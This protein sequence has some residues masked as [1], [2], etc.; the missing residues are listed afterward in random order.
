[1]TGPESGA[2]SPITAPG[3]GA[4]AAQITSAEPVKTRR[5][6]KR[7]AVPAPSA[8]P[9]TQPTEAPVVD[10][11]LIAA[12]ASLGQD[13][14]Q[15]AP[16]ETSQ[17]LPAVEPP[18][19][20]PVVETQPTGVETPRTRGRGGRRARTSAA[21]AEPPSVE[22]V[23]IDPD[24]VAAMASLGEEPEAT[25]AEPADA[26][27]PA[28]TEPEEAPA[29]TTEPPTGGRGG[30]LGWA[31]KKLPN[32]FKPR[33]TPP[34]EPPI[35]TPAEPAGDEEDLAAVEEASAPP[36]EP[37]E[38]P[39]IQPEENPAVTPGEPAGGEEDRV[40]GEETPVATAEEPVVEPEP[41]ISPTERSRRERIIEA[42]S[43]RFENTR[44]FGKPL[45]ELAFR[46]IGTRGIR[47]GARELAKGIVSWSG[48]AGAVGGGIA[49][50]AVTGAFV[51]AIAGA[52]VEYVRQ[53]DA[54]LSVR[55]LE[56][57]PNL[58][59][60]RDI[61]LQKL[62]ETRQHREVFTQLDKGKLSRAAIFGAITGAGAG[63]IAEIPGVREFLNE[64]VRRFMPNLSGV[65]QAA[66]EAVKSAGTAGAVA[67][68]AI[69]Q[70][71]GVEGLGETASGI[72]Q[73][74]GE[75][76]GEVGRW[77][78]IGGAGDAARE[79]AAK[80]IA[81][82][83]EIKAA[84]P[85]SVVSK[86][87]FDTLQSQVDSL[88]TQ[89]ADS[90]A[91]LD[92]LR[93]SAQPPLTEYV[94]KADFANLQRDL[95]EVKTSLAAAREA[96][97]GVLPSAEQA[98]ATA[99][100]VAEQAAAGATEATQAQLNEAF[101]TLNLSDNYALQGGDSVAGI[102]EKLGKSLGLTN[103]QAW[104]LGK[105]LAEENGV[106]SQYYGTAGNILDRSLPIGQVMNMQGVKGLALE[107]LK[108]KTKI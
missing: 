78:N 55:A 83:E 88:N 80:A 16:A 59:S 97:S 81:T 68:R 41:V 9:G 4:P 3:E 71:P 38:P 60:R 48:A 72:G 82:G 77:T 27:E 33:P 75:K 7:P 8:E 44:V 66:S 5:G 103:S 99:R 46:G 61:F 108:N 73:A 58:T 50:T 49:G 42:I 1:M 40:D 64:N 70:I 85:E 31:E 24:L 100:G 93:Q 34:V 62:R 39:V 37:A 10:P 107:M 6:G 65:G 96:T 25:A 91:A 17:E 52:A 53:V 21:P 22:P 104:E 19:G 84:A 54:N 12:M 79:T 23:E 28:A 98:A 106:S 57:N 30:L 11:D 90:K 14:E 43:Y 45:S 26:G 51:G 36:V 15:P 13:T 102:T 32:L 18:V 101:T 35:V 69:G 20:E 95:A 56:T 29:S 63:A 105:R 47:W 94:P 86:A 89:L 74:I 2:P 87:D 92:A 76:A 67:G